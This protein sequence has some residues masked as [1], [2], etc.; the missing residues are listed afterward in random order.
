MALTTIRQI[1]VTPQIEKLSKER[2]QAG[3]PRD[4]VLG[5]KKLQW[6]ASIQRDKL[7]SSMKALETVKI[8]EVNPSWA[9]QT[10]SKPDS[11]RIALAAD[12]VKEMDRVWK[13]E[14][15]TENLLITSAEILTGSPW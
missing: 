13:F 4:F 9:D 1:F 7:M 10:L 3:N 14:I 2:S 5:G 8:E 12:R 11:I 15:D 6:H